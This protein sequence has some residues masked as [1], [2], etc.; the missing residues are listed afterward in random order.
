MDTLK[1]VIFIAN[2]SYVTAIIWLIICEAVLDYKGYEPGMDHP[3]DD[4][5]DIFML[6]FDLEHKTNMEALITAIYFAFTSLTTVGFG[7]YHPRGNLERVCGAF[8]LLSGVAIFSYIMGNF[9]QILEEMKAFARDLEDADNLA[10]FFGTM[11]H[12]NNL[13]PVKFEL[14]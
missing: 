10:K 2:I 3:S 8:I 7:D 14:M 1:L 12:F 11:K 6:T 13:V 5:P 9:I 4:I